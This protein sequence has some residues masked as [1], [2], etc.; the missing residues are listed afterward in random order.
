MDSLV[1]LKY[2]AFL[3]GVGSFRVLRGETV[4]S[5]NGKTKLRVWQVRQRSKW[6]DAGGREIWINENSVVSRSYEEPVP[7]QG[8]LRGV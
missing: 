2:S 5:E 7:Q 4:A 8:R 3:D 6:V 1:S